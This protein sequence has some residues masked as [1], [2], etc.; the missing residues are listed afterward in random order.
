ML[1]LTSASCTKLMG[2]GKR[3]REIPVCLL[4]KVNS[5]LNI[6]F[7]SF[8]AYIIIKMKYL[9]FLYSGHL[10]KITSNV[11]EVAGAGVFSQLL[12]NIS[13]FMKKG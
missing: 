5:K 1:A 10:L 4:S 11:S 9:V 6:K 3:E 12:K 13:F 2:G 7:K 8:A